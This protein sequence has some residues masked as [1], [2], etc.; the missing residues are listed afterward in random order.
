MTH[1]FDRL[2]QSQK[3]FV[4]DSLKSAASV[5]RSIQSIVAETGECSREVLEKSARAFE[6]IAGA[7]NIEAV[8]TASG[9]CAR[10]L[11][12]TGVAHSARVA[13]LYAQAARESVRPLDRFCRTGPA[14]H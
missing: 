8:W 9:D 14:K 4:A 5:T 3:E 7:N 1:A 11:I 13:D 6:Q 10:A 2:T 12:E